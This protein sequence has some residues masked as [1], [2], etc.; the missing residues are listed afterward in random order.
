MN[1]KMKFVALIVLFISVSS[2]RAIPFIGPPVYNPAPATTCVIGANGGFAG[3]GLALA[4]T[5]DGY[6]AV[7]V[8]TYV[9]G[10][11]IIGGPAFAPCTITWTAE[12]PF[13]VH[14]VRRARN[15]S[16][17]DVMF[18][19]PVGGTVDEFTN[20]IIDTAEALLSMTTATDNN[21]GAGWG[22]GAGQGAAA[23]G[24]SGLFDHG[25]TAGDLLRQVFV[26]DLTP[27]A[28]GGVAPFNFHFPASA[29]HIEVP[30]PSTILLTGIGLL[31]LGFMS[32]RHFGG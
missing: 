5:A 24:M 4:P 8:I 25:P 23:M 22:A 10:T 26:I 3:G 7:G 18:D 16:N 13:A 21:A 6:D 15:S 30:E 14:P 29:I 2:A 12:R 1:L 17:F 28:A 32:Q 19:V 9:P 20:E 27:P 11:R 31:A